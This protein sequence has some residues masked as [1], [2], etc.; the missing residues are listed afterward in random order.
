LNDNIHI[1]VL[2]NTNHEFQRNE[3]SKVVRIIKT[4]QEKTSEKKDN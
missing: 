4:S 3:D 1:S 2:H